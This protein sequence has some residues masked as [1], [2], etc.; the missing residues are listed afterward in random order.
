[1]RD[2]KNT[3]CALHCFVLCCGGIWTWVDTPMHSSTELV[4][5]MGCSTLLFSVLF[6]WRRISHWAQGLSFFSR[7]AS[8]QAPVHLLSPIARC[9]G[10][11]GP[12]AVIPRLFTCMHAGGSNSGRHDC[13]AS[14]LVRGTICPALTYII[15][16]LKKQELTYRCS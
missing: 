7:L 15:L 11:V 9:A 14:T 1:M 10:E 4:K 5:D 13:T 8:Q 6:P 12:C 16:K 2:S 3:S